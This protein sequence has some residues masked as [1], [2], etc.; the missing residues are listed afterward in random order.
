MI[1]PAGD[2]NAIRMNRS[3]RES[4]QIEEENGTRCEDDDPDGSK[5]DHIEE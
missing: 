4:D 1:D 5:T 2:R 3:R